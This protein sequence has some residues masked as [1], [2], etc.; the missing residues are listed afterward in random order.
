[1][2]KTE[3]F[4]KE[5]EEEVLANRDFYKEIL[6]GIGHGYEIGNDVDEELVDNVKEAIDSEIEEILEQFWWI[7]EDMKPAYTYDDYVYEQ[8]S[9]AIEEYYFGSEV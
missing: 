2:K 9:R 6:E 3:R 1:M 7:E 8:Q 5:I 4:S